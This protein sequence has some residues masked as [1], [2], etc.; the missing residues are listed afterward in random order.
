MKKISLRDFQRHAKDNLN[1]LPI[2]LTVGEKEVAIVSGVDNQI[3]NPVDNNNLDKKVDNLT[4]MMWRVLEYIE[5][6]KERMKTKVSTPVDEN[7]PLPEVVSAAQL[8]RCEFPRGFCKTN[9]TK[10]YLVFVK[11]DEKED[12]EIKFFCMVHKMGREIE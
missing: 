1:E 6:A 12:E 3:Q 8:H 10:K 11:T 4:T 5:F 9:E 7:K 2:L